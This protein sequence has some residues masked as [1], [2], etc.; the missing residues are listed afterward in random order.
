MIIKILT[1]NIDGL[2]EKIDL[3]ELPWIFKPISWIYKLIKKTTVVPIND[4]TNKIEN[5]KNISKYLASTNADIIAVQEDFNYHNELKEFLEKN[6]TSGKYTGGITP[7]KLFS[8]IKWF[9]IPRFKCDG[10]TILTKTS[11]VS[12]INEIIKTWKKS[13]GYFTHANDLLILKGF[14]YYNVLIDNKFEIDIYIVHMDADF[15]VDISKDIKARKTQFEQLRDYIIHRYN[16]GYN[17]PV[18]IMGDTNSY[19]KYI[20]DFNNIYENLINPI[21]KINNLKIQEAVPTNFEDCDRILFINNKNSKYQLT[22]QY[23]CFQNLKRFSDHK[24]LMAEFEIT[25]K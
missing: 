19:N 25:E 9:P 17:N 18:I 4:D 16:C 12:I 21:N 1:Y 22:L 8:N 7:L 5:I 15:L 3:K 13:H 2:P 24:P 11:R 20:W 10:I 6:Y 14:R 23:C